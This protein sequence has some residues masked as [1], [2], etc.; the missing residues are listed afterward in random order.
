[1]IDDIQEA[2]VADTPVIEQDAQTEGQDQG[3]DKAEESEAPKRKGSKSAREALEK[4]FAGGSET[5][6]TPEEKAAAEAKVDAKAQK[7]DDKAKPAEKAETAEKGDQKAE[8]KPAKTEPDEKTRDSESEPDRTAPPSRFSADAKAEWEKAPQS[9]RAETARMQ[10]ELEKGLAEKDQALKPLEPFMKLA[11]D[12]GT[13]IDKALA[14]YVQME[15]LLRKDP[16]QGLRAL[17][18]N[19]GMNPQQMAH[20]L[21]GGQQQGQPQGQPGQQQPQESR[22]IMALR[23]EIQQLKSGMGQVQQT[24]Q[25]Q[26][27]SEVMS[28]VEHFA[29]DHP[30]FDELS[31]EIAQMLQTGYATDL[32]DAYTKAERLSPPPAPTPEPTPAAPA[33]TR[34][35]RSL[36]GAPSPGSDP[37][38]NRTPSKNPREALT[39]AFSGL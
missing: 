14:N 29:A 4:A 17:A 25:Q 15:Q 38:T 12:S 2:P 22:E 7:P 31:G 21:M 1:M 5:Q 19:M 23:Q 9:V 24:F 26:K 27:E 10:R 13:T 30:R 6:P 35:P 11:K 20:L 36:T 37:T 28:Q 33:Q 16:A 3:D 18:Q 34:Q 39:R 8:A 32:E